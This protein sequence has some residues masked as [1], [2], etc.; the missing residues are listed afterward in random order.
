MNYITDIKEL[1][2]IENLF[3]GD[4][5][6]F[7]TEYKL[8]HHVDNLLSE[9]CVR[10]LRQQILIKKKEL[11]QKQID[12]VKSFVGDLSHK[13]SDKYNPDL[14][15]HYTERPLNQNTH[16]PG[17]FRVH[18][19]NCDAL[20][21]SIEDVDDYKTRFIIALKKGLTYP[22]CSDFYRAL[23]SSYADFADGCNECC[24]NWEV[25]SIINSEQNAIKELKA[26]LED[27]ER[28]LHDLNNN[29]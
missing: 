10:N 14:T 28:Q 19:S 4:S 25:S 12:W 22:Q 9:E 17:F 27:I 24:P 7:L 13:I 5:E 23:K 20:K 18:R 6:F 16:S 3:N 2:N 29:I 21:K 1:Y 8:N 15:I 11:V 26:M